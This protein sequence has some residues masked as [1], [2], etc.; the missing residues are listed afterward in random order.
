MDLC[1]VSSP[2]DREIILR[3]GSA[4]WIEVVTNGVDTGAFHSDADLTKNPNVL[5]VANMAYLPNQQG[6]RWFCRRCWPLV[7]KQVPQATLTVVG[8]PPQGT[9]AQAHGQYP[10]AR[11]V[12]PVADLKAMLQQARVGICPVAVASGRQF[13]VI[14]Y[15][16]AGLPAVTTTLVAANLDAGGEQHLLTADDV[17]GFANQVLRLLQDDGLAGRLRQAAL[18]LAHNHYDWS[19]AAGQLLRLY[20]KLEAAGQVK[21]TSRPGSAVDKIKKR[22]L[23]RLRR[24]A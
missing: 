23:L 1:L 10:G 20:G 19:V 22:Q 3:Q 16:A 7:K 11:F 6:L 21:D 4:P 14:E 15:F 5:F 18:T 24:K 12:G 8:H 17:Q 13:K 2:H 9:K